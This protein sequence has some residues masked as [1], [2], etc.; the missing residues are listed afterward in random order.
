MKV[1]VTERGHDDF[2][3]SDPENLIL[4]EDISDDI[5]SVDLDNQD[6]AHIDGQD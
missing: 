6:D 2:D 3:Q 1:S 4:V 5:S